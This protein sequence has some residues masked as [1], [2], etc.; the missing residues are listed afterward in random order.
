MYHVQHHYPPGYQGHSS[1]HTGTTKQSS[2]AKP[3]DSGKP[4]EAERHNLENGFAFGMEEDAVRYSRTDIA[5]KQA[6]VMHQP[7]EPLTVIHED[8]ARKEPDSR[9]VE[10]VQDGEEE[11]R[12]RS[13]DYLT[14][15]IS[16][17]KQARQHSKADKTH[18]SLV[19]SQA[20]TILGKYDCDIEA[21][22]IGPTKKRNTR[23]RRI[24]KDTNST[25]E[26]DPNLKNDVVKMRT[27]VSCMLVK[28][29]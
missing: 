2:P 10:E 9:E 18:L 27:H 4:F 12:N 7:V 22:C 13:P 17:A 19:P 25:I 8:N 28:C 16:Q 1:V 20:P 11:E 5:S 24:A 29:V 21:D 23:A 15:P 26:L 6:G 3:L 14:A